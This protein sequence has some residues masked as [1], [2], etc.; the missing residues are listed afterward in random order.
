MTA[1]H[2][3]RSTPGNTRHAVADGS[4]DALCGA[5]VLVEP[6]AWPGSG[7]G[8]CRDCARATAPST[9]VPLRAPGSGKRR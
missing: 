8:L 2:V 4:H 1:H 6:T 9:S 5:T 3:G 7:G